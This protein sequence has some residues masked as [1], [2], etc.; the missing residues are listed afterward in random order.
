MPSLVFHLL[1]PF[2][3][4]LP[5]PPLA[6]ESPVGHASDTAGERT[7]VQEWQAV[8]IPEV[9][10]PLSDDGAVGRRFLMQ[11][12]QQEPA[13]QVRI[14]QRLIIRIAPQSSRSGPYSE[15]IPVQQ[16]Q[17]FREKKT[18]RCLPVKGIAGV[19][20]EDSRLILFMRDRRIIGANL[21]KSC[22]ARDFYSGF[23]VEHTNDGMFCAGRD[24]V[25]SRAGATCI[26]S[27]VR[28]MIP[29]D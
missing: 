14:D 5:A 1:A 8:G 27:R 4:F 20:V 13:D 26:V 12:V 6:D 7:A 18:S 19:R 9:S 17:Q 23:Y 16:R 22:R 10:L 25:H 3:L 11:R 15:P 28:E 29:D 21:E 2:A 24:D